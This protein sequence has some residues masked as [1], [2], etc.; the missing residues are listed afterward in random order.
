MLIVCNPYEPA[1]LAIALPLGFSERFFD[2]VVS[3][4]ENKFVKLPP[5]SAPAPAIPASKPAPNITSLDP[6]NARVGEA[7]S[8]TVRWELF[9]GCDGHND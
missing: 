8:F 6:P 9:D 7:V 4:I 5:N 1:T 3:Q 2:G